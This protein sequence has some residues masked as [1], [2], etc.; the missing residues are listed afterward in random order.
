MGSNPVV[1]RPAD[2]PSKGP[3]RLGVTGT[4]CWQGDDGAGQDLGANIAGE[5]EEIGIA[6]EL[7]CD[8]GHRTQE[9]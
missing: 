8:A 4:R 9:T 5:C 7:R 6:G 3:L 2:E 1:E